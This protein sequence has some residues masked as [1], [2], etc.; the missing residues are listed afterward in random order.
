MAL[1]LEILERKLDE[2][3]AKET[4]ESMMKFLLETRERGMEDERERAN[5]IICRLGDD[6]EIGKQIINELE[7]AIKGY[8]KLCAMAE[9]PQVLIENPTLFFSG[10]LT[11][12]DLKWA[13]G[14]IKEH[15]NKKP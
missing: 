2:A 8:K 7:E 9:V 14:K 11:K 6:V 15:K 4:P 12:D 10:K 13:K 3:L 5:D 1:D